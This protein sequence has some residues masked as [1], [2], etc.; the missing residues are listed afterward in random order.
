MAMERDEEVCGED[1]PIAGT[2]E[3]ADSC[4]YQVNAC[5]MSCSLFMN[6]VA[7]PRVAIAT[8]LV[9]KSFQSILSAWIE[10]IMGT[11]TLDDAA[12]RHLP[13]DIRTIR[14]QGGGGLL[15]RTLNRRNSRNAPMFV[16]A[17]PS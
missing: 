10:T 3:D 15:I 5:F 2:E 1:N 11:V 6:M 4:A 12:I 9:F 16:L 8:L 7:L 13:L 14:T 17:C